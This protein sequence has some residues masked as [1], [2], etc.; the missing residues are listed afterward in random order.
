MN[1][2]IDG[3]LNL[4]NDAPT[5]VQVIPHPAFS[6]YFGGGGPTSA[7]T[8]AS[9]WTEILAPFSHTLPIDDKH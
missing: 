8:N 3:V 4:A 9:C 6:V 2:T 1:S 7:C 5:F